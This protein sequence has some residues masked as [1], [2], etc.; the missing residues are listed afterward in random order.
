MPLG[1][2]A[3]SSL[4][5]PL[6]LSVCLSVRL[7]VCLS[8][9]FSLPPSLPPPPR[10]RRPNGAPSANGALSQTLVRCRPQTRR[11]TPMKWRRRWASQ[12]PRQA[13][14]IQRNAAATTRESQSQRQKQRERQSDRDR[15]RCPNRHRS[16]RPMAMGVPTNRRNPASR[17]LMPMTSSV[18]WA[19][20]ALARAPSARGWR[21]R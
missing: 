3:L 15:C 9:C 1:R 13:Q 16:Q 8:V 11:S 6:S 10:S 21:V 12:S 17:A 4:P 5:M 14:R 7:P 19:A 2:G 20:L 18:F